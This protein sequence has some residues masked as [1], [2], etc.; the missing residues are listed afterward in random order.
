[1]GYTLA[2]AGIFIVLTINVN[3]CLR[4]CSYDILNINLQKGKLTI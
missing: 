4:D 3:V 1:M 2:V